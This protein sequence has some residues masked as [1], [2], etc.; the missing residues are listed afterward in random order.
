MYKFMHW[1]D[2]TTVYMTSTLKTH[3]LIKK[4]ILKY[5]ITKQHSCYKLITNITLLDISVWI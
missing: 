3:V 2:V 1:L 5:L 4:K